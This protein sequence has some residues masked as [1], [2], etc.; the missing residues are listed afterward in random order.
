MK[1]WSAFSLLL[2]AV[3]AV[4]LFSQSGSGPDPDE[5]RYLHDWTY[6]HFGSRHFQYDTLTGKL[7]VVGEIAHGMDYYSSGGE[8]WWCGFGAH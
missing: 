3:I 8:F 4:P 7:L 6:P 1:P 5:H 2:A